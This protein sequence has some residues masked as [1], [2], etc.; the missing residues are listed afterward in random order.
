MRA[1][2]DGWGP[3]RAGTTAGGAGAGGRGRVGGGGGRGG[4]SGLG[5]EQG[6]G[7]VSEL[8]GE[9]VGARLDLPREL[10]ARDAK[11]ESRDGEAEEV[12]GQR[13]RPSRLHPGSVRERR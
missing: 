13:R 4:G 8:E 10:V 2:V 12:G 9:R 3:V 6:P 5:R 7:V 1:R 11:D